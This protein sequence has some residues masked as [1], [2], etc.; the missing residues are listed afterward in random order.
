MD[1]VRSPVV[2]AGWHELNLVTL[3][4]HGIIRSRPALALMP[5]GAK[6]AAVRTWIGEFGIIPVEVSGDATDGFALRR[7][8]DGLRKG[9][10]EEG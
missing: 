5:K 7:M 3:A 2:W 6:G 4:L 9:F 10:D 8:R 1:R